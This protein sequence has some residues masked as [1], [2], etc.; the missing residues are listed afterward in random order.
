MRRHDGHPSTPATTPAPRVADLDALLRDLDAL[1]LSVSTDLSLA[2]AA[3]DAGSPE[4]AGAIIDSDRA[5]LLAFEQRALRHLERL[6]TAAAAATA[7]SPAP[8]VLVPR[9][10]K[11]SRASRMLMPAGPLLAAAAAVLGVLG[12]FVATPS[13]DLSA[14]SASTQTAAASYAEL[15]RLT[16]DGAD[17]AQVR[18][19]AEQLHDELAGIVAD[20]GSNPA[21]AQEALA[22]LESEALVLDSSADRDALSQVIAEARAMV[23]RLRAALPPAPRTP[24]APVVPLE[25]PDIG[26]FEVPPAPD[27]RPAAPPAPEPS[28]AGPPPAEPSSQPAEPTQEP[29]P[30]PA[31]EPQPS[32]STEPSESPAASPEPSA[33]PDPVLPG[34]TEIG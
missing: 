6:S 10:R 7:Q 16:L 5:T 11:R 34:V 18:R 22:L 9:P 3:L 4:V 31:P 12:G 13:P 32:S 26:V 17:A 14:S 28:P 21:A 19:A 29:A 30:E 15:T 33:G 27:I 8:P 24:R 25:I 1:R 20:A 2:A 23:A